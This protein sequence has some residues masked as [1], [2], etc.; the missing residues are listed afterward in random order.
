MKNSR[1]ALT[2]VAILWLVYVLNLFWVIDLRVYGIYPRRMYGLWG[3]LFSPFLHYDLRHLMANT[4]AFFVL[5]ILSLSFSKKLTIIAYAIIALLGG[6]LVWLFGS[7]DTVHIGAS[8]IIFGLMAFLMFSGIFRRE[9]KTL[10]LS[11]VVFFLYGGAL[12]ALFV[13]EPGISWTGH[14]FGFLAGALAAW[15]TKNEQ[16]HQRKRRPQ[17]STTK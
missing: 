16:K 12:Y 9:L 10:F 5:L 17:A 4:G 11:L 8:G 13:F 1:I 2:V 14:F 7:S 15:W 3:I 6:G